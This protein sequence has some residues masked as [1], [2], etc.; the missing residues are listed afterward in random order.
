MLLGLKKQETLK[1]P[2]KQYQ[3]NFNQYIDPILWVDA[4]I[5]GSYTKHPSNFS[6]M[7]I[8][9]SSYTTS[10]LTKA[11]PDACFYHQDILRHSSI[12]KQAIIP[13]SIHYMYTGEQISFCNDMQRK[14]IYN[15]IKEIVAPG[16]YVIIPYETD[17]GWA[18]YK[19]ILD[20]LREI[21]LNMTE[22]ITLSWLDKVFYE[23][24][25]LGTKKISV[26][27]N[28]AF[29]DKLLKYL[30]SI[31]AEHFQQI[32][33]NPNFYTF[34]PH[35]IQKA[36]NP[37]ENQEF[38][39]VGS[40]PMIR[41]YV[42][43]GFDQDQKDF[44]AN[45]ADLMMASQRQDLILMPFHRID[46]W[47]KIDSQ[48][49]KGTISDFYLG[50]V[51]TFDHFASS[52]K[53]GHLTFKFTDTIYTEIRKLLNQ[54]FMTIHEIINHTKH[55]VRSPQEIVDR[56][57]LLVIGEQIRFTL[58]QPL[59]SKDFTL[60]LASYKKLKFKHKCNQSMFSDIRRFYKEIGILIHPESSLIIPFDQKTSM[61]ITA[62][63]KVQ[64]NLAPQYCAEIWKEYMQKDID[65]NKVQKEFYSILL[66]FKRHYL[67]KFLELDLLDQV[68]V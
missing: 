48:Q 28:K 14:K 8:G 50:C 2:V 20:L 58:K 24:E 40:L 15:V 22:P 45:S 44:L 21:T 68:L 60:S 59:I 35:H 42:N 63:T 57:M 53:K 39:F 64:E 43:L 31:E 36:L 4:L 30:K 66:F 23:L 10:V 61:I 11:Y 54:N 56:L 13:N 52:V 38:R 17:A 27:K 19:V 12:K 7:D 62:L 32:L 47:Q 37:A 34:Y 51:S 67:G 29:L 5:S 1:V 65:I 49:E 26:F 46:I 55:L 25:T 9:S 18:E 41:N 6:Y 16:G 33:C 3:L